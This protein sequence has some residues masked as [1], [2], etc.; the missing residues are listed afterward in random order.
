MHVSISPVDALHEGAELPV[1]KEVLWSTRADE[2]GSG[3]PLVFA[4]E[5]GVRPPRAWEVALKC[6]LD[7]CMDTA[8]NVP[9]LIGVTCS[10]QPFLCEPAECRS[11]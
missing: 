10:L 8:E 2:G 1:N 11:G 6:K 9:I 3:Q 5:K 7:Q 4:L